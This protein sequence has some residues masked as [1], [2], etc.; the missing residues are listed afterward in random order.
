MPAMA[1]PAGAVGGEPAPIRHATVLA[2]LGA[3][4]LAAKWPVLSTPYHWDET[5]WIHFA[6]DLARGPLWRA[7]PGLHAPTEFGGRPP[8]LFLG[9]A[10]LFDWFCPSIRIAHLYIAAFATLGVYFAYRLGDLLYG[11]MAGVLAAAFLFT[12]SVYFAQSAMFLADLP[13]AALGAGCVYYALAGKYGRYFACAVG[14]VLLKETALALVAAVAIHRALVEERGGLA[15]R[16]RA[17]FRWSAPALCIAPYYFAQKVTTGRF[18]VNFDI[19]FPMFD[20]DPAHAAAQARLVSR[21][22][23][24]EQGRWILAALVTVHLAVDRRAR[25]SEL[26]LFASLAVLAGYSYSFLYFLPRYL[27]PVAPY[28][29]VAAAGALVGLARTHGVRLAVGAAIVALAIHRRADGPR[30]GTRE[31]SMG[32]LAVVRT[33]VA[34]CAFVDSELGAARIAAPWPMA[35]YLREPALGCGRRTHDAVRLPGDVGREVLIADSLHGAENAAGVRRT[36]RDRGFEL[37]R[38]IEDDGVWCEVYAAPAALRP[39][40]ATDERTSS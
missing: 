31:W 19:D 23:F 12:D 32:Y 27:L 14:V 33:Y 8:G 2:V 40:L 7:L 37:A 35:A 38:R 24:V 34:T 36:A 3:V 16:M 11:T 5:V 28:L 20:P 17:A 9:M 15:D 25:R 13:T 22:L 39:P 4:V 30:A 26:L 18:F 29:C 10:V 21:W 6:Q 1:G